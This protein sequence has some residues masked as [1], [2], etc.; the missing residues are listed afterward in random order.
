MPLVAFTVEP[1]G[2]TLRPVSRAERALPLG[3][4][5]T[6]PLTKLTTNVLPSCGEGALGTE[7]EGDA[8]TASVRRAAHTSNAGNT[9]RA[10]T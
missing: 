1:T 4:T 6:V 8:S 7:D 2:M 5:V 9:G 10:V 3:L